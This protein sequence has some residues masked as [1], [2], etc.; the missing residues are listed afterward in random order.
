MGRARVFAVAGAIGAVLALPSA[1]GATVTIGSN[2]T[3]PNSVGIG[4]VGSLCTRVQVSMP[5]DK[6]AANGISS[7]VNGTVTT[8]RIKSTASGTPQPVAFRVITPAANGQYTGGGSTPATPPDISGITPFA[9]SVPIKIGDLLGL[10]FNNNTNDYFGIRA[11]PNSG[12]LFNPSL[13]EGSTRDPQNNTSEELLINA[14]IEPTNTF[15]LGKPKARNGGKVKI[16]ATLPNAGTLTAGPKGGGKSASASAVL[17]TT[18]RTASAPGDLTFKVKPTKAT[19]NALAAGGTK[20]VKIKV[21]FTPTF[22][23]AF[24]RTIKAKLKG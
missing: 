23:T 4:C 12:R 22:G 20:K 6:V 15:T 8:W 18:N 13:A 10:N 14:D 19:Q 3:S 2:L 17:K 7:P 1:A 16:R 5:A 11:G 9:G 21:T 24:S